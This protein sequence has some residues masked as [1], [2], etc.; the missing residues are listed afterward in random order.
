MGFAEELSVPQVPCCASA[1][2]A[3]IAR[4]FERTSG[5]V[6]HS[7][8]TNY[9]RNSLGDSIGPECSRAWAAP[10]RACR[11]ASQAICVANTV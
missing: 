5:T 9:G 1:Y 11:L 6:A 7:A 4:A 10:C 8:R 2:E 3:A